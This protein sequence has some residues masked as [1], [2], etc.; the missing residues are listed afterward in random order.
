MEGVGSARI[1]DKVCVGRHAR[2]QGAYTYPPYRIAH[3]IFVADVQYMV[4]F[5]HHAL[6]SVSMMKIPLP[7]HPSLWDA[8]TAADWEIQLRNLKKSSRSRYYCLDS[9][10]ES[11][12]SMK[13][14]AQRK[15]FQQCFYPPNP[16]SLHILIHG[17]ASAIG[18]SKYRSI[19]SSTTF[20]TQGLKTSDFDDAL[21]CWRSH[22]EQLPESEQKC[23]LSWCALIMYHFSTV[24][25]RNSLPDIQMA[26]GSAFSSG[27]AVTPQ[28]AQAAYT[29][30]ISNNIVSHDTYLHGLEVVSL[31]LQD[32]DSSAS[33]GASQARPLWQTYGAFLGTLVLWARTVGLEKQEQSRDK[34]IAGPRPFGSVS[35]PSP[36]ANILS[37]MQ[38]REQSQSEA[39]MAE[40]RVLKGELQELIQMVCHQLTARPWEICKLCLAI[41]FHLIRKNDTWL[42]AFFGKAHEAA[43][44]LSSLGQREGSRPAVNSS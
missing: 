30:L 5:S 44:I 11:I 10:V 15:E 23:K 21:S 19:G 14:F 24:L 28:G 34:A 22:F 1:R 27:R 12:M 16:L 40:M 42:T 38:Y 37:K 43:R 2:N 9:A 3:S 4:Y 25:L 41:R 20:M 26:A 33:P 18:D 36:A 29:R 7:S 8:T 32:G 13:N 17:I 6:L 39:A 31:C 35:I